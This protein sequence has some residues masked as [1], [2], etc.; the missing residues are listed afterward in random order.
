MKDWEIRILLIEDNPG[1]VRLIQEMLKEGNGDQFNLE[2]CN[3]LSTGLKILSNK[4]F[5]ILLLDLGLPDSKGFNTVKKMGD[6]VKEIPIVVLTGLDNKEVGIRAVQEGAQDYLVKGQVKGN[7]LVSVIRHAIERKKIEQALSAA[8]RQLEYVI[9]SSP[10]ITY[11]CEASRNYC[12]KWISRNV[13]Q[14]VGYT[15]KDFLSDPNFWINHIHPDDR[16]QILD[17]LKDITEEDYSGIEYRF[18]HKDG[19]YH[20]MHDEVRVSRDD[21]GRPVELIGSWYDVTERKRTEDELRKYR[22]RL[23][24]LVEERTAELKKTADELTRSNADLKE[25]AYVVSHDLKEPLQ[26]M[27]GF[28]T[29]LEKRYK[30][31][32]DEKANEFIKYTIDSAKRMQELIKD[33]LEYSRVGTKKSKEFKPTDCSL[34]LNKVISNLQAAIEES[35]AKVTNTILPTVMADVTQLSSLFQNLIGNAIKFR[36]AEAPRV[37]IS[38]KRKGDE[39]LFSV[40]DNGIGIDPEFADRI[41]AVFQRLHTTEQYPG[42]GIGLAICKK[43]VERHGGRIWVESQP[44]KGATFYFTIPEKQTS[45]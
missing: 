9:D 40:C 34:I 6:Q 33:L 38:A 11:I 2:H 14:Q 31:K 23:E 20:W 3:S 12:A 44:G 13:S 30:D 42:T 7:L 18:L 22:E 28:L 17:R 32:L 36:G 15:E 25:F 24:E 27:R 4:N 5:D 35:R 45:S 41:F 43:I 19:D 16:E 29:L 37:H 26:A 21:H 39:W 8:K 1:D 10:A